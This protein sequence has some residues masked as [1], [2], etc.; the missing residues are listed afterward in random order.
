MNNF[1]FRLHSKARVLKDNLRNI[2]QMVTLLV[3]AQPWYFMALVLFQFLQGLIPLF[4]AWIT[5]D[6]FDLLAQSFQNKQSIPNALS[7]LWLLLA[8]QGI[9]SLISQVLPLAST[10]LQTQLNYKLTVIIQTRI[11]QKIADFTGLAYFEDPAFHDTI[12]LSANNAQA[13]PQQTLNTFTS[14]LQGGVTLCSFLGLLLSFHP[15]LGLVIGA[16]VL[17]QLYGQ[18]RFGQQRF[19]ILFLQSIKERLVAYYGQVLTWTIFAKEVRLFDLGDYFLRKFV[20]MTK[21]IYREQSAQQKRELHWQLLLGVLTN[22]VS[23]GIFIF[24]VLQTFSG[25]LS[26]GDMA[27]YIS[28]VSSVQMALISMILSLA[29]LQNSL[30]FFRHYRQ[31]LQ[32]PQ[33]LSVSPSPR[34]VEPLQMGIAF[35]DVSFRYGE[36]HPW[37]LRHVNL[38]LPAKQCLAL[39][40][41]N[42]AGKTTLVKLL[43]RLYDPTEGH[44]LWDGVDIREFDPHELRRRMGAIFQDFSHYDLSVRENIGLG[45][46]ELIEE[47]GAIRQ[48]AKKAGVQ[49][50]IECLPQGYESILGRMLAKENKGVD[51]SGGEWQ[52]VALARMFMRDSEIL[53][54]DEPTAALDAAAEYTLYRHFKELMQGHTCLLITHRFSTVRMADRVAVLEDGQ[55]TE[56]GTHTDLLEHEGTYA[57]LY[58]MQAENY[59]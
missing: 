33:P 43:T 18:L 23:S 31:L 6:L 35:C 28:A 5:K 10:Y 3:R 12:Q 49:E 41:L 47:L 8:A 20:G 19:R 39:I 54:L 17:P 22:L 55:I 46:V 15:L 30:R 13:G 59:Q 27:L 34:P 51:L 58:T 44:I 25:S 4:S 53:I 26:L 48:A 1:Y 11:Y 14:L 38:F 42:G 40:G 32:L 50:R 21:E 7:M 57:K 29:T 36:Q 52:K 24:V 16:T 56:I 2:P 9:T 37:I 45:K